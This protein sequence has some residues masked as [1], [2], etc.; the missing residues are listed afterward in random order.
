[1][2]KTA[3]PPNKAPTAI[4]AVCMGAALGLVA[5][6]AALEADEVTELTAEPAEEVRDA[7]SEVRL[8]RADPVAVPRT[9]EML[10]SWLP[11][12]LV[13][14]LS[15]ELTW[16]LMLDTTPL[17]CVEIE[18]AEDAATDDADEAEDAAEDADDVDD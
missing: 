5:V 3:A 8:S 14:E 15:A 2:A 18:L 11:S 1:L 10:D 6:L 12:P 16:E 13:M 17:E 4:A 7:S 9:D